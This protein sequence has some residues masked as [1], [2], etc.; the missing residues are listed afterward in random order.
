[1]GLDAPTLGGTGGVR[2]L[3]TP[4]P[5]I[6]DD[7]ALTACTSA[8]VCTSAGS[9]DALDASPTDDTSDSDTTSL[10]LAFLVLS[11][12]SVVA[13]DWNGRRND[14]AA[15]DEKKEV[16]VSFICRRSSSNL[17]R[18]SGCAGGGVE[19]VELKSADLT[20]PKASERREDV[21]TFFV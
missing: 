6:S 4:R 8:T 19:Q 14:P 11:T 9:P 5:T 1:M 20:D 10:E 21:V 15:K 3:L 12:G 13:D 18:R 17:S 2:T 16:I 7:S